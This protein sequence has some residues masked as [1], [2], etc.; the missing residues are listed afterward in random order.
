MSDN[1]WTVLSDIPVSCFFFVSEKISII[2]M[3]GLSIVGLAVLEFHYISPIK[4]M[5]IVCLLFLNLS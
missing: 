4:K 5:I 3:A 2:F 1:G